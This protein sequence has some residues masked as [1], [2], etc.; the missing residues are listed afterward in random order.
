IPLSRSPSNPSRHTPSFSRRKSRLPAIAGL[1]HSDGFEPV[2]GRDQH[3]CNRRQTLQTAFSHFPE[4]P[5]PSRLLRRED[6]SVRFVLLRKA[7]D[8]R[9]ARVSGR[10]DRH[11]RSFCA[12]DRSVNPGTVLII[13]L[14]HSDRQT[15]KRASTDLSS[16]FLSFQFHSFATRS[17]G[18]NV[19]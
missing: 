5:L 9:L 11:P 3:P 2:A 6:Q 7:R 10:L 16:A 17:G 13:L 14:A 15:K 1:F 19:Y 18:F 8:D 4:S 12:A